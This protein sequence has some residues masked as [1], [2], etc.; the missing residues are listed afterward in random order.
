MT[1]PMIESAVTR[2]RPAQKMSKR[3]L[4]IVVLRKWKFF[5]TNSMLQKE[6]TIINPKRL[7]SYIQFC[8]LHLVDGKHEADKDSVSNGNLEGDNVGD[9]NGH[10]ED[11]DNAVH[12]FYESVLI[13]TTDLCLVRHYFNYNNLTSTTSK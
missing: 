4:P 12:P 2:K 11:A 10:H 1:Q 7:K 6:I 13:D 9:T 5:L 3:P 8:C